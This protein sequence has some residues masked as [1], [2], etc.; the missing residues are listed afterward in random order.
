M[1]QTKHIIHANETTFFVIESFT[2]IEFLGGGRKLASPWSTTTLVHSRENYKN[3]VK[4]IYVKS[5][6]LQDSI[7]G[8]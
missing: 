8:I 4:M 3:V 7:Q 6:L 1:L 2:Q 5:V